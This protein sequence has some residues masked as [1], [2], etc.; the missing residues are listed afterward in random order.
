MNPINENK[1]NNPKRVIP[2]SLLCMF[3]WG[4]AI[5]TTKLSYDALQMAQGEVFTRIYFA[6]LRFLLASFFVLF[7][8][9]VKDRGKERISRLRKRDWRFLVGMGMMRITVCYFFYY[10]ALANISGVKGSIFQ[11]ASTFLTVLI[12]PFV[13]KED[14]FTKEKA[15]ALL[16]GFGGILVA[17]VSKGFDM[18]VTMVGEGF[19]LLSAL[20]SALTEVLVK[21]KGKGISASVITWSQL[22]LGSLPLL[23]VGYLFA[24]HAF[25]WTPAAIALLVYGSLI[26][27]VAFILWYALLKNNDAGEL[28]LYRLFIPIFGSLISAIVLP[29]DALTLSLTA[30]LLL[31]VAGIYVL[32][33]FGRRGA[34]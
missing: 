9:I 16:L 2:L 6:G 28:A 24:E 10:I 31:V 18:N 20:G 23:I 4:S 29:G 27:A 33:R 19:M 22:L 1:W 21:P 5:P 12:A 25:H 34:V 15:A 11:S 30:G 17:N 7:Y 3:L 26:S 32:N 14:R 8:L 13:V